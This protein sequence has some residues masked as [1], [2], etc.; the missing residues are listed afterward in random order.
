M[1]IGYARVSTDDQDLTVQREALQK[2]GCYP[3][4]EE[5]L[6]G[7]SVVG[8]VALEQ[9]LAYCRRG[10]VFMVTRLDRLGRNLLELV[11]MVRALREKGVEFRC[12]LQPID[13][14]S[15][16][17]DA[18]MAMMAVFA[19]LEQNL[20]RERQREGIERAKARGVYNGTTT[21][22]ITR[23]M[24]LE[25]YERGVTSAYAIAKMLKTSPR[26]V[27]RKA[28]ELWTTNPQPPSAAHTVWV[29]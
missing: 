18:M 12:L 11:T 8:R 19:E 2:A 29:D 21:Q 23:A 22:K 26:T 28:P 15:P 6:S 5:K 17:G 20:R 13:T 3:I 1:I 25:V 4:F 10:D 27:Y 24:V 7:N 9:A 16:M 14:S